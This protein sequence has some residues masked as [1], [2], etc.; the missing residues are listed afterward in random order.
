MIQIEK[1]TLSF[2]ADLK[3]N[4]ERDWFI[5]NRKRYEEAKINYESFVQ[6]I[7]D[8]ISQFDPTLRGLGVRFCTYRINRDIRF[9]NDKSIYKT[10]MGAFIVKGGKKFG[11]RFAGYYVHIE[12]GNSSMIAG[13]AYVPPMPW[14]TAIREKI[15]EQGEELIRI[16]G[17]KDFI[18]YFGVIEGEKLRS[19]PKGFSRDH[20]YIELL[21][22]KSFLVSKTF[23]DPVVTGKD[24]YDSIIEA[25]RIMKP[26]NDFLNDY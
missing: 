13:G 12:P 18:R 5:K 1:S 24:C 6:S 15:D 23:E 9:S 26:L 21:K 20:K 16:L 11:D 25:C 3:L 4:N 22:M 10:Y 14:L 2:L 7:I 17:D 19:A 8:E